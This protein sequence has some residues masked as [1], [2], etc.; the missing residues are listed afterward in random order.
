MSLDAV[1]GT[2]NVV[3][4]PIERRS[5]LDLLRGIAPDGR[6]V[7]VLADTFEIVLPFDLQ[8]RADRDAAEHIL[9]QAPASGRERDEMLRG[10][11]NEAVT[12]AVA[13]VVRSQR[14]AQA[15]AAAR[16]DLADA[17]TGFGEWLH[18]LEQAAA[19]LS[20]DAAEA[21][22]AAHGRTLQAFG[23][24]RAVDLAFRGEAWTPRDHHAEMDWLV[25]VEAKRRV[26]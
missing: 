9:N 5:T 23:V 16:L 15:A 22:V 11:S 20:V 6:E 7:S 4:F 10:M 18:D 19:D 12:S 2:S 8:D 14:A 1:A 25:D 26:G 21:Q 13:A 3:R 17:Q 24:A